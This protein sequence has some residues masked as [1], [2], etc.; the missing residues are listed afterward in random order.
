MRPSS[1]CHPGSPR[2][3]LHAFQ[4]THAA[5]TPLRHQPRPPRGIAWLAL[6]STVRTRP[7]SPSTSHHL[8]R[9]PAR[10]A[11]PTTR[12]AG[13]TASLTAPLFLLDA[14][15]PRPL[16]SSSLR[17]RRAHCAHIRRLEDPNCRLP[18]RPQWC[19]AMRAGNRRYGGNRIWFSYLREHV[20]SFLAHLRSA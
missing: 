5:P 3:C 12:S 20:H 18:L 15:S 6:P 1:S 11:A 17:R 14:P 13:A 9:H 4:H 16:V 7:L 8:P 2:F 19:G 10:R